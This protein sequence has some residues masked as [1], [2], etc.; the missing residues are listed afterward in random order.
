MGTEPD[1]AQTADDEMGPL[2]RW[3]HGV[4]NDQEKRNRLYKALFYVAAAF[5]LVTTLFPFYWLLVLALTP[6]VRQADWNVSIPLLGEVPFPTPQGFNVHAF[7][8]V[9]QQ[10]PFHLYVFNSFVLATT[11]T[12]IV[13]LLASLAGYVFGRL[14]F[15]G[16]GLMMLAILAVSY[17][18][19]AAFLIPLFDAFLGNA[20]V[21]PFL[22][23]ELFEPPRLVN[24]P[25]SMIMPFSALFLPLSIFIL[26]TFYAQIPDGLEDAA[27]VEGTTRLGALFRVI[28]PLSAPGVAT[29]AVLTFIAVY[30]EY[31]FSSIM[32]LNNQPEQWSPLVGGI[33]SYQTQYTTDFN[34]MAAAS[35]VGVLPMLIIVVVAQEKIVSGLTEGALKE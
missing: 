8:E 13:L 23:I 24:T 2:E 28:M 15:P 14:E 20:V 32:A 5:F 10:V 30:N 3:T 34:L 26:T 19:P 31:F 12:I 18:P 22:G 17:F 29:A 7:V 9:F 6:S 11:T 35:I 33:L 16:R 25:G 1:P 21:V 4:V 27:R